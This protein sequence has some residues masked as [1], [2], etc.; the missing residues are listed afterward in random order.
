MKYN[1][2]IWHVG[3]ICFL[4]TIRVITAASSGPQGVPEYPEYSAAH[5]NQ[6]TKVSEADFT[7]VTAILRDVDTKWWKYQ[8][9]TLGYIISIRGGLTTNTIIV[10]LEEMRS[11]DLIRGVIFDYD[12]KNKMWSRRGREVR[13]LE[14]A[15][16]SEN[17]SYEQGEQIIKLLRE[18]KEL[19]KDHRVYAISTVA[20]EPFS[21]DAPRGTRYIVRLSALT[22]TTSHNTRFV[23]ITLENT[24]FQIIGHKDL[25]IIS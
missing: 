11:G 21:R 23:Y 16:L 3:I 14:R 9:K 25:N 15:V 7:A 20:D 6:T 13:M 24:A 18:K 8:F 5:S 10:T 1:G 2:L 12:R 19:I 22:F 17:V 4:I